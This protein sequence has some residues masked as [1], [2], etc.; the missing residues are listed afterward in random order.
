MKVALSCCAVLFVLLGGTPALAQLPLSDCPTGLPEGTSCFSGQDVNGAYYLIAIPSKWNRSLWLFSH[1]GP[2]LN[3]P[4]PLTQA[5]DLGPTTGP[6][7][8]KEGSAVAASSYHRSGWAVSSDATDTENLRQLFVVAFGPTWPTVTMGGSFG[9]PVTNKVA[10]L[11][12]ANYDGVFAACGIVAGAR[13]LFY[14]ILDFRVV[15]QYYCNN[16]PRPDEEQYPL[17]LSLPPGPPFPLAEL[18]SRVNECTGYQLPPDQRSEQQSQNLANITRVVRTPEDEFISRMA[19]GKPFYD[20]QE[21]VQVQ[22]GGN[23]PF[24]NLNVHYEGS[25]DDDALNRGV[26]RYASDP[27]TEAYIASD[28]DP[29]GEIHVPVLTIHGI[30]DTRAIVEH[31][32]AYQEAFAQARTLDNL[33]QVYPDTAGHCSFSDAE[34]KAAIQGLLGWIKTG[35][36]P[37]PEDIAA[38]CQDYSAQ[39]FVDCRFNT[40]FQPNSLD[41]VIY[42]RDP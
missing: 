31:E 5:S 24:P 16:M 27:E 1:G 19:I 40:T 10:E 7:L 39:G 42:P 6:L 3:P 22:T 4:A 32:A 11:F 14:S 23:N 2:R 33:L 41:S 15:Y 8:L 21:I 25:M 36:K 20:L 17:Y 18:Q 37:T 26:A 28:A 13:R 12:G 34:W 30:R 9:G 29:T 35:V 38:A